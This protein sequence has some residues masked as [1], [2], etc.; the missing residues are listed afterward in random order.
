M[1]FLNIIALGEY[2]IVFIKPLNDLIRSLKTLLMKKLGIF[3]YNI[4][5]KFKIISGNTILILKGERH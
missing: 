4:E 2:L 1:L 5:D 3:L